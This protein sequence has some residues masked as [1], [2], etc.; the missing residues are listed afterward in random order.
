MLGVFRLSILPE[1]MRKRSTLELLVLFTS[2]VSM[3][4][5]DALCST[6]YLC[7]LHSSLS[8]FHCLQY[9]AHINSIVLEST[10]KG[11]HG[12]YVRDELS[13][14]VIRSAKFT[15]D[16]GNTHVLEAIGK[17]HGST[18]HF[19]ATTTEP[20]GTVCLQGL[21][22]SMGMHNF[23]EKRWG[24]G[25]QD[26]LRSLNDQNTR[27]VGDFTKHVRVPRIFE[28]MH[29]MVSTD[30]DWQ[31][32]FEQLPAQSGFMELNDFDPVLPKLIR[33]CDWLVE[34]AASFRRQTLQTRF[35]ETGD[36]F[37]LGMEFNRE[38]DR[39]KK[40]TTQWFLKRIPLCRSLTDF[41]LLLPLR[42]SDRRFRFH[43]CAA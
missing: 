12:G 5:Y 38:F 17:P 40:G 20:Y 27:I 37:Y 16:V 13:M 8:L 23:G 11:S 18:V 19:R 29:N 31:A 21:K 14:K 42:D 4:T 3:C 33:S 15:L 41:V 10:S 22:V 2:H 26:D 25:V 28:E 9:S 34:N 43:C 36:M 24:S 39:W 30:P 35:F 1:R 6:D 32:H 7:S